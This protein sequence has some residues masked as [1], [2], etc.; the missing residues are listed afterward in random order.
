MINMDSEELGVV[1]CGCAG[2]VRTDLSLPFAGEAFEGRAYSITLGGLHGGHSGEDINR[3]RANANKLMGRVLAELLSAG[4]IRLFS[5][6]GGAK[7]NA[8]PRECTARICAEARL[9]IRKIIFAASE[10][11]GKELREC[12]KAFFVDVQPSP[13]N[14]T[15]QSPSFP[16]SKKE[17]E[18]AVAILACAANG[19]AEMSKSVPDLVESSRNLGVVRTGNGKMVFTFSSRSSV[20][21]RLDA[22]ERELDLLAKVAGGSTHHHSRYPGWEMR[23][24]SPLRES[25]CEA[26][27]KVTGT[28]ARINVI[29][30]GLECGVIYSHIPD[31]DMISV[32]P[33]MFDI[34]SPNEHLDLNAVK[35]FFDT[36]C[37]WIRMQK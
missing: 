25:Y 8:I 3:G 20:E 30:A 35:V 16:L 17:T 22:S 10:K 36:I 27:R 5:I 26:Y 2:G 29:H 12:D 6:D 23:D 34:H 1:T 18:A 7:D 32:G 15:P 37:Q 11:I 13:E 28:D 4:D 33:T 19:V 14:R 9:D 21:S 31:M 24:V